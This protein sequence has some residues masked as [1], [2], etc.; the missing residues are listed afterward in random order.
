MKQP[1]DRLSRLEGIVK[2]QK[3]VIV[4]LC[5]VTALLAAVDM[6]IAQQPKSV[7]WVIELTPD[8]QATY[9][10]DA[11]KLLEDWTPNDS[12]QRYFMAHYV[13]NMR[14]VSTDNIVNRENA[15]KVF[16]QTLDRAGS[17]ISSWYTG[18]N[19]ITRSSSMYVEV[20]TEELSVVKYTDSQWKVTWRETVHRRGDGAVTSDRQYEGIFTVKF[21][22]PDTERARRENPIGMYVVDYDI[23]LL[24]NL[25]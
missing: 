8:G 23:D 15:T 1:V 3:A 11:V 5:A 24:K 22:T 25:M 6:Y 2:V 16:A 18:N 17:A 4:C 14:S 9:Y 12:T 7:P 21:Y 19:P 10:E 20:P 13:Q